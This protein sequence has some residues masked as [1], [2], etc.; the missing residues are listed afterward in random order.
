M[1]YRV[2]QI[3]ENCFLAQCSPCFLFSWDNIDRTGNYTWAIDVS[4]AIHP[5]LKTAMSSINRYRDHL[6]NKKQYPKYYKV[7]YKPN[8]NAN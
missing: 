2:K 5:S 4:N 3:A 8:T 7:S 6:K 1:Q